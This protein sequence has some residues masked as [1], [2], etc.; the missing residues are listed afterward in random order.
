MKLR[1]L[2]CR[3]H[4]CYHS[5]GVLPCGS[6]HFRAPSK[7]LAPTLRPAKMSRIASSRPSLPCS[8]SR[9]CRC[10][11]SCLIFYFIFF[12][13]CWPHVLLVKTKAVSFGRPE[14]HTHTHTHTHTRTHART[15][16]LTHS[17]THS[18]TRS[19]TRSL[20]HLIMVMHFS[21]TWGSCLRL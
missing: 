3:S 14:T 8:P 4:S 19:L 16:S 12:Y 11:S 18:H 10:D 17:F 7:P 2:A 5:H 20:L 9:A 13:A 1:T 6:K 15:P 21:H